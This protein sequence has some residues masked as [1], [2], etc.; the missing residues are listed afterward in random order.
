MTPI[1]WVLIIVGIAI[2]QRSH[3][4]SRTELK[5]NPF[6]NEKPRDIVVE[7]T[8]RRAGAPRPRPKTAERTVAKMPEPA[9]KRAETNAEQTVLQAATSVDLM[10]A[11]VLSE[12]LGPPRA[13][14][15]RRRR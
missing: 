9:P 13:K 2:L 12:I 4:K 11:V 7:P 15:A 6:E 3:A 8:V 5:G 1:L 10:Q 14:Q